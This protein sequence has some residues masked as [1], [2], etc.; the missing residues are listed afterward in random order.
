MPISSSSS[1]CVDTTKLNTLKRATSARCD[2]ASA[3]IGRNVWFASSLG[4]DPPLLRG[5]PTRYNGWRYTRVGCKPMSGTRDHCTYRHVRPSRAAADVDASDQ[6]Y[7]KGAWNPMHATPTQ[8]ARRIGDSYC[9]SPLFVRSFCMR[10]QVTGCAS[11]AANDS[12]DRHVRPSRA[13]ADVDADVEGHE[14]Q[15]HTARPHLPQ[16]A[17]RRLPLPLGT[18]RVHRGAATR[19]TDSVSR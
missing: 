19:R 9:P 4:L 7:T 14:V 3:D 13:A 10:H 11:T 1:T 12:T 8:W 2:V 16:Q 18:Q 15:A 17:Q 6:R 5:V